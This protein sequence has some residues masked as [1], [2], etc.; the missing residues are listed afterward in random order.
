VIYEENVDLRVLFSGLSGADFQPFIQYAY[1]IISGNVSTQRDALQYMQLTYQSLEN[2]TGTHIVLLS[3]QI[4]QHQQQQQQYQAQA[5]KRDLNHSEVELVKKMSLFR[6]QYAQ[7]INDFDIIELLNGIK[8]IFGGRSFVVGR[9]KH[10]QLSKKLYYL[11]TDSPVAPLFQ[12]LRIVTLSDKLHV[13]YLLEKLTICTLLML[14]ENGVH[15]YES[16]QLVCLV[17]AARIVIESQSG[18][19]FE[20]QESED[21][22][23]NILRQTWFAVL[24]FFLFNGMSPQIPTTLD[25]ETK[26]VKRV[27]DILE[28]EDIIKLLR[29]SITGSSY[30]ESSRTKRDPYQGLE[31]S[32]KLIFSCEEQSRAY[33]QYQFLF[34]YIASE[35]IKMHE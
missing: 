6:S 28:W 20:Y 31:H 14:I 34:R 21:F 33:P 27:E 32:I 16:T 26:G 29:N 13:E 24:G 1:G 5:M 7:A 18:P 22:R 10:A 12:A 17:H 15:D 11:S 25:L 23:W 19:S 3:Q 4:Q 35:R 8:H 30:S 2:N 9:C